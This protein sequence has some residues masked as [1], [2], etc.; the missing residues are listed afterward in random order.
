[1]IAHH[2][3]EGEKNEEAINVLSIYVRTWHILQEILMQ[4]SIRK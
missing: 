1:M 4:L 2:S 3:P